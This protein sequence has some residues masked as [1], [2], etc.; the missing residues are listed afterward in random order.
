MGL[1]SH[2]SIEFE[3]HHNARADVLYSLFRPSDF[4]P[5]SLEQ[6][7]RPSDATLALC[8]LYANRWHDPDKWAQY[9][10]RTS[11]LR[12]TCPTQRPRLFRRRPAG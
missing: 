12:P 10:R 2:P 6:L 5:L 7:A 3:P 1:D 11:L 4:Q 9:V 8:A